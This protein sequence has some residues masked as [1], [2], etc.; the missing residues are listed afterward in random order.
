MVTEKVEQLILRGKKIKRP[1]RAQ[2]KKRL[3]AINVALPSFS[4]WAMICT[5]C[6]LADV[7]KD[8]GLGVDKRMLRMLCCIYELYKIKGFAYV[9]ELTIL[10][11]MDT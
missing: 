10:M 9:R 11:G 7:A 6:V 8:I 4:G 1:K 3:K 2:V 5:E